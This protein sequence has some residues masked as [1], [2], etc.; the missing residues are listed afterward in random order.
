MLSQGKDAGFEAWVEGRDDKKR[1]NEHQIQHH[2]AKNGRSAYAE[3]F[4]ET[5][6]DP[7][8]IVVEKLPPLRNKSGWECVRCVDGVDL[9]QPV[10]LKEADRIE[11][12]TVYQSSTQAGIIQS[13]LKFAALPV[14]DDK[15]KITLN[16][17]ALQKLGTIE[18][19]LE[20]GTCTYAGK[21]AFDTAILQ[22]GVADEKGRKFAYS[23]PPKKKRKYTFKAYRG[24]GPSSYR[25]L[26]KYRPRA[27]LVR[28]R[29]IDEP[30]EPDDDEPKAGPSKKRK[31]ISNTIDLTLSE[32]EDELEVKPK[33]EPNEDV[34][35]NIHARRNNYLEERVQ[36]LIA[37]NKRLREAN[38]ANISAVDLTL[39]D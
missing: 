34:K 32:D 22:R 20:R 19:I 33:L 23:R 3:C 2:P 4:L 10:W 15:T 21:G 12:D 14:S 11:K 7:F 17:E 18:I 29:I 31:R 1:L 25:F 39:N 6:D 35:P 13:A 5:I 26:F 9:K 24:N 27:E 36:D 28:T 38:S 37:E 30:D 16:A 8:R